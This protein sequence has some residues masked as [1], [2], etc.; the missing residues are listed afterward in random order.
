MNIS[1]KIIILSF[2]FGLNINCLSAQSISSNNIEQAIFQLLPKEDYQLGNIGKSKNYERYELK[3]KNKGEDYYPST[4][5]PTDFLNFN[6]EISK[7]DLKKQLKKNGHKFSNK[8]VSGNISTTDPSA[9]FSK[10]FIGDQIPGT[11][12]IEYNYSEGQEIPSYVA[13]Y[14]DHSKS[15]FLDTLKFLIQKLGQPSS[16]TKTIRQNE[17]NVNLFWQNNN[18]TSHISSIV[19]DSHGSF[20]KDFQTKQSLPYSITIFSDAHGCT[21]QEEAS[22]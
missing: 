12:I 20:T 21:E 8:W 14:I 22:H 1:T 5:I 15:N 16:Y 2:I 19:L 9:I 18:P 7:V 10:N 17:L 4:F 13:I 6:I 11:K 3:R